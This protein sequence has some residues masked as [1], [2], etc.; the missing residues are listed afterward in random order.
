MNVC[1]SKINSFDEVHEFSFKEFD[2]GLL[3]AR[4]VKYGYRFQGR[5][6]EI[7]V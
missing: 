7:K 4:G 3:Y 2:L 5:K 6:T 1:F